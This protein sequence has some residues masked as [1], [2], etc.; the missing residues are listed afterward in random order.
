M[1][2]EKFR[3]LVGKGLFAISFNVLISF[4][5]L[6]DESALLDEIKQLEKNIQQLSTKIYLHNAID[7]NSNEWVVSNIN[8]L[9]AE[10]DKV[11]NTPQSI[12][13][14]QLLFVN[15]DLINNN[16]DNLGVLQV[17]KFL[18]A[19]NE[20]D[21][22]LTLFTNIKQEGDQFLIASV[23][24]MLAEY[25]SERSNWAQV[26]ALL[27]DTISE[28]PAEF[29]AH[30]L[31]L[32]GAA[33]QFSKQHRKALDVYSKIPEDSK[34]R[35]YA[36][37]NSAIAEI[38]QGWITNARLQIE[39]LISGQSGQ[40]ENELTNRLYLILGYA[41]LQKEYYRDAR[42]AFRRISQDS[43]YANRAL[44]GIG[45]TATSQGDYV[46]GL[47]MLSI[48]QNKKSFDLSREESFLLL[49]YV[50]EKLRQ[51]ITA[52]ASY[53]A[54]IEYYQQRLTSLD[55]L[56]MQH[57]DMTDIKYVEGSGSLIIYENDFDYKNK[58]PIAFLKNFQQLSELAEITREDSLKKK[59]EQ[60]L[61]QHDMILQK[62][63][64][65]LI[66][67]RKTYLISYLNQSQ[68]GLA[69]LYDSNPEAGS[70]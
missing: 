21:L 55:Q 41:L 43:Q 17:I 29:S 57:F 40:N 65:T 24:Y 23:Q 64:A 51:E 18:L 7:L 1:N 70:Q 63:I 32:D 16:L 37:L 58:F 38:R 48:L 46:G 27:P 59:I 25:H 28:L 3:K 34:Y 9:L 42:N 6:A 47:N 36:Q 35:V 67:R 20:L 61:S 4:S 22:A 60:L 53:T 54:A 5:S 68:Y 56:L 11:T 66:N 39:A 2:L 15:L 26:H 52:T 13:A 10:I 30:A 69:R 12:Q 45:L 50:Y 44:L 62:I 31:L 8:Q 33:L 49:P 14:I 19:Y